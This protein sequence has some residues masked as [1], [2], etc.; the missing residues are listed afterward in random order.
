MIDIADNDDDN[1]SAV[2][3]GRPAADS[4][5]YVD[6]VATGDEP[7]IADVTRVTDDRLAARFAE[8]ARRTAAR[9]ADRDRRQRARR[10]GL[11]RRHTAKLARTITT[12]RTAP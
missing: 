12:E 4:V 8:H 9:R 11:G 1:G 6:S 10:A 3:V 7:M 2:A 5:D